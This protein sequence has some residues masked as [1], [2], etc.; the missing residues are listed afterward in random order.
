MPE[1]NDPSERKLLNDVA[2]EVQATLTKKGFPNSLLFAIGGLPKEGAEGDSFPI[3]GSSY[4][5]GDPEVV[6][7]VVVVLMSE[8]KNIFDFFSGAVEQARKNR[9]NNNKNP[10]I[11]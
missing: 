11:N 10:N 8:Q 9:N 4:M 5:A 1:H 7:Q 2:A 6:F 3:T